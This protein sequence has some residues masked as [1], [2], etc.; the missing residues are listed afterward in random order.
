MSGRGE[1]SQDGCQG[2]PWPQSLTSPHQ[3]GV[4]SSSWGLTFV[5]GSEFAHLGWEGLVELMLPWY[6]GLAQGR[7]IEAEDA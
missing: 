7:L 3:P 5:L 6:Q 2:L 1:G 4:P